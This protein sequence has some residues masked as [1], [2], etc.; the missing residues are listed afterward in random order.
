MSTRRVRRWRV[1]VVAALA[2][3]G[4][5]LLYTSAL[6]VAATAI[7]L[8]Y[9][10]Y[11][12]LSGLPAN[13]TLRIERAFDDGS[14]QPDE[15]VTV[16]LTITNAGAGT[17]TDLRMVDGVPDE[18]AVVDGSP[19][20]SAALPAGETATTSY[21]VVA[22]RGEYAFADPVVRLRSLAGSQLA[23]ESVPAAGETT[24]SCRTPVSEAPIRNTTLLRAGT[25]PTDSGGEGVEF[26]STREYQPGDPLNRIHWR[27]FAKSGDLTTI[28]YRAERAVRTVL[29]VDGRAL[30]QVT[31]RPGSPTGTELCGYAGQRLY[32]ALTAADVV[33]SVAAVGRNASALDVPPGPGDIPW[34]DG[35]Q[36][37]R[38]HV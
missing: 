18:L 5:G 37:G 25:H 34:V 15:R 14:P 23:T 32:E 12:A 26:R 30:G 21:T 4:L 11:G 31:L 2:L 38:A 9:V 7:P 10:V 13:A 29:V 28:S 35:E 33:T 16:T 24:L 19:R 27:Q 20:L 3:V 1:G 22:K 36:I 17:L 6:L 8:V